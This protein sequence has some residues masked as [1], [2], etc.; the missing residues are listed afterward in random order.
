MA[1]FLARLFVAT[2]GLAIGGGAIWVAWFAT[3]YGRLHGTQPL[4]SGPDPLALQLSRLLF[5][6]VLPGGFLIY[7][8]I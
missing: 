5:V 4:E 7:M 6:G 3:Q 8:A 2:L 1:Y